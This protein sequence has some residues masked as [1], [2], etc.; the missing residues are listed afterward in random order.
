MKKC[1]AALILLLSW[2]ARADRI[3]VDL[4]GAWTNPIAN[5]NIRRLD[6]TLSFSP[7]IRPG[8]GGTVFFGQRLALSVTDSRG[9][10]PVT[11]KANG[12]PAH[13]KLSMEYRDAI[14]KVMYGRS[15]FKSYLGLG[16]A[17]PAVHRLRPFSSGTLSIFRASSPDHA[18]FIVNAGSAYRIAHHVHVFADAKYEPF[19][20][21]AEVRRVESPLDDLESNFHLLIIASGLSIR[22]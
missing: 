4:F 19:A 11:L 2:T 9:T 22:F 18:A 3:G 1:M 14:V 17:L 6:A 12:P 20:S 13:S 21:T 5:G 8:F 15:D 10:V 7:R 16:L